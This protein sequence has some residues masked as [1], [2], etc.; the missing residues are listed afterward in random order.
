M[1]KGTQ[2]KRQLLAAVAGLIL[3]LLGAG[4]ANADVRGALA[5]ALVVADEPAPAPV[6]DDEGADESSVVGALEADHAALA[7][8]EAKLEEEPEEVNEEPDEPD[9]DADPALDQTTVG[10]VP[11]PVPAPD[12]DT[13][14]DDGK[15]SIPLPAVDDDT[16]EAHDTDTVD[17]D[18]EEPQDGDESADED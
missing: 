1:A 11:P 9:P 7:E 14:T 16:D 17:D 13:D 12:D 4:F 10:V 3:F 8:E 2:K 15:T 18:A 6:H 5:D